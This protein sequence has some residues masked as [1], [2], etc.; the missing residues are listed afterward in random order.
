[1]QVPCR[2]EVHYIKGEVLSKALIW[3]LGQKY[4]GTAVATFPVLMPLKNLVMLISILCSFNLLAVTESASPVAENANCEG[5]LLGIKDPFN[6]LV[7]ASW[8]QNLISEEDITSLVTSTDPVNPFRGKPISIDNLALSLGI[9]RE[10]KTM[11]TDRWSGIQEFLAEELTKR[12]Q[13]Q[14]VRAQSAIRTAPILRPRLYHEERV[15]FADIFRVD[16]NREYLMLNAKGIG[17]F[18]SQE[19][20]GKVEIHLN[21]YSM[22]EFLMN[23]G[24]EQTFHENTRIMLLKGGP[25]FDVGF[26]PEKLFAASNSKIAFI[27]AHDGKANL[28]VVRYDGKTLQHDKDLSS[29][30]VFGSFATSSGELYVILKEGLLRR[31]VDGNYAMVDVEGMDLARS[32]LFSEMPD[33]S[34]R[35]VTTRPKGPHAFQLCSVQIQNGQASV[36][37][38]NGALEGPSFDIASQTYAG[39]EYFAIGQHSP[40][41]LSIYDDLGN[42]L[43]DLPG[44]HRKNSLIWKTLPDGKILLS[45]ATVEGTSYLD[46]FLQVRIYE[47]WTA[48]ED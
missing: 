13:A 20:K 5:A 23:G 26:K 14:Q 30:G 7:L 25:S 22:V 18:N 8:N 32:H 35:I 2:I 43:M 39:I 34:V 42:R 10:L 17:F 19:Y 11:D 21:G 15:K 27:L 28:S 37:D 48:V 3:L 33:G 12:A 38:L 31:T 40:G 6:R 36:R 4:A 16:W 45:H 41:K 24:I 1:M 46:L 9:A 29:A 47:P 44:R